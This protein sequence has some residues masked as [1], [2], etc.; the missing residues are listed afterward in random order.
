MESHP[1]AHLAVPSEPT[2][3]VEL[4]LEQVFVGLVGFVNRD[5]LDILAEP[6]LTGLTANTAKLAE[7][8]NKDVIF[9]SLLFFLR[10]RETSHVTR[11]LYYEF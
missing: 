2:L 9:K 4:P 5:D 8:G 1:L 3:Q 6:S 11:A 10:L 7:P